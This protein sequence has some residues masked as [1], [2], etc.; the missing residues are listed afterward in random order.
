MFLDIDGVLNN[1]FTK[2]TVEG[3]TFV[4]ND[5]IQMLKE[6]LDKTGAQI[7][8]TSYWRIG[9]DNTNKIEKRSREQVGYFN[10]LKERLDKFGIEIMSRTEKLSNRG[11]EID[12]WLKGWNGEIVESYVVLDDMDEENIYPHDHR[13]VQTHLSRGLTIINVQNAIDMLNN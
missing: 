13:L 8:L 1:Y 2:E 3:F 6:I 11:Q 12:A 5:K 9:W 4:S 10:A 7:V